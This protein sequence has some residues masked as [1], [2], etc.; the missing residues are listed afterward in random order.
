MNVKLLLTLTA[1]TLFALP[2][3]SLAQTAPNLG[4]ASSFAL[5]T[6]TGALTNVGSSTVIGDIGTNIGAISGFNT[7]S[8]IGNTRTAGSPEAIQAALDVVTAYNSLTAVTCVNSILPELA[9]QT[10]TSGIWCQN[11]ATPTSL[12]GTLT[13]SGAGVFIIKLNSALTTATSSSI[14]LTN[15]ATASNVFFQVNG[16]VTLG[17]GSLF[18]GTIIAM[19]AIVLNTQA[20]LEGRA[21]STVGAI[22]LNN[23]R[24]SRIA[25]PDLTPV[26]LLPLGNF[27]A[28]GSNASRDFI[29]IVQEVAGQPT[30]SGNIVVTVSAP[31]GYNLTYNNTLTQI[32]V[33]GGTT[34]PV[35]VDNAR[36]TSSAAS[37]QQLTLS[38]KANE[39]ITAA[40]QATLGFTITRAGGSQGTVNL[41]VNVSDDATQTYDSNSLN[42]IYVRNINA[43]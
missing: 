36:W 16:A 40:G 7:A 1:T 33:S 39:F 13:L 4:A 30:S 15:G 42:N 32:S 31:L 35:T 41:T 5:F 10:L 11:T 22:T 29:I 2:T 9:G 20:A 18:R 6:A 37:G 19:G 34:N 17:T 8:V 23:N 12:N 28:S 26:I 21:L 27:T 24:V 43:L 3:I 25:P 38:I 14:I